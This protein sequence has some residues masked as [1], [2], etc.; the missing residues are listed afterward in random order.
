MNSHHATTLLDNIPI[1][2][3]NMNRSSDRKEYMLSMFKQYDI[4][5]HKRI[6]A[7]DGNELQNTRKLTKNE[8]GCLLSHYKAIKT[9]HDNDLD[10][11]I[12]MEDDVD[13]STLKYRNL[14]I[15]T[16]FNLMP[17]VRCIQMC[18]NAMYRS[19]VKNFISGDSWNVH[20]HKACTAMYVLNRHG[21]L[22]N[23][24]MSH[25][26]K[27]R[28]DHAIYDNTC[29]YMTIPY[30]LANYD[31]STIRNYTQN[32]IIDN[33]KFW[34]AYYQNRDK[35][36]I[37][38]GDTNIAQVPSDT[39][40]LTRSKIKCSDFN[41][42]VLYVVAR[43]SFCYLLII[44]GV[45]SDKVD[46]YTCENIELCQKYDGVPTFNIFMSRNTCISLVCGEKKDYFG[47]ALSDYIF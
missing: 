19:N 16:L 9:A 28:A 1:Y 37:I 41:D 11:V 18:I 36:L 2:W 42:I 7:I 47:V 26:T 39:I 17:N 5:N 3:V 15:K 31:T 8:L 33:N 32:M 34:R 29:T 22:D 45:D 21:I 38:V 23:V 43:Y 25:N 27:L 44:D 30:V 4:T 14:P 10:Y 6:E 35:K 12:I 40:Y 46:N 13:F 20:G 24:N